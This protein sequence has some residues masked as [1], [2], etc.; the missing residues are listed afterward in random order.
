MYL[1]YQ[2]NTLNNNLINQTTIIGNFLYVVISSTMLIN[3]PREIDD[4]S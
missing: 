2:V 3:Y 1:E 4:R